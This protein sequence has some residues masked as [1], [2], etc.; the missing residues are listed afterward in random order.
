[1]RLRPLAQCL[2]DDLCGL[3]ALALSGRDLDAV[4]DHKALLGG[5]NGAGCFPGCHNEVS[6][7]TRNEEM[8]KWHSCLKKYGAEQESTRLDIAVPKSRQDALPSPK[9][10]FA[11]A[12][13]GPDHEDHLRSRPRPRTC[14]A[15]M[16]P[17]PMLPCCR[18]A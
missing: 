18:S 11:Q 13:R 7:K 2:L 8:P 5:G 6:R 16:V 10:G 3:G 12:G 9:R 17:A 15:N 1:M 4:I 14:F